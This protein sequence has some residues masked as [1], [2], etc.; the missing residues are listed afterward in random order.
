[1]QGFPNQ[2]PHPGVPPMESPKPP[3]RTKANLEVF[4]NQLIRAPRP[5]A[6]RQ[7]KEPPEI[8]RHA[9]IPTGVTILQSHQATFPDGTPLVYAW[10]NKCGTGYYYAPSE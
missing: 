10:C 1:M 2:P 6:F 8:F 9:C 4:L 5:V 3:R 7:F